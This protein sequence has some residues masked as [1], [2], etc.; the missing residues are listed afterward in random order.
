[1]LINPVGGTGKGEKIYEKV[2]SI[3]GLA[4]IRVEKIVTDRPKHATDVARTLDV[5]SYD[6][7]VVVGGDG[8]VYEGRRTLAFFTRSVM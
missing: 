2:E 3:L 7:L 8:F 1:M 4:N 5:S 6:C